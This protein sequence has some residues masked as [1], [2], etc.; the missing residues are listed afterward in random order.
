MSGN[1]VT[2]DLARFT[3]SDK[4]KIER[5]KRR[6]W[7]MHRWCRCD[8]MERDGRQHFALY[9]GDRSGTPYAS[10]RLRRDAAGAYALLD[11]RSGETLARART[12]DRVIDALPDDFYHAR[13]QGPGDPRGGSER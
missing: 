3:A 5:L 1:V 8:L 7:L 6:V 11:G 10:Y 9:S 12:I 2:L 4:N 13:R